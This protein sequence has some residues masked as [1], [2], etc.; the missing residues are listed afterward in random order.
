MFHRYAAVVTPLHD[1]VEST[2]RKEKT[3]TPFDVSTAAT[4][5][6]EIG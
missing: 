5:L 4:A 3:A 1:F 6:F 2:P